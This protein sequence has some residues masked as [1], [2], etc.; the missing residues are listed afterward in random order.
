MPQDIALYQKFSI[1]EIL[2]YF[3]GIYGM[4]KVDIENRIDFLMGFLD[5][6]E[7]SRRISTM[8]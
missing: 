2:H 3:G 1:H 4:S 6:P 8:R 7:T 5:L